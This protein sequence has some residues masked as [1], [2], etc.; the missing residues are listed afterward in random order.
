MKCPNCS[1]ENPPTNQFCI[2]CGARL[3]IAQA[4][5]SPPQSLTEEI[6]QLRRLFQ[7]MNDRLSALEQRQGAAPS[8]AGVE[9]V[10]ARPAE[11]AP[12]APA[13]RVE[14]WEPQPV[15]QVMQ[16]GPVTPPVTP[17]PPAAPSVSK[18][19]RAPR[20]WEQILG[21]NW[22]ARI[23]AL[24]LL[25]GVGFFLKFAFDRNWIVPVLRI[26]IGVVAGLS[27]LGG[28]YL[29]R[30]RYPV[31][32]QVLTGGGIGV[33]YLSIFAA[34]ATYDILP[35]IA[36]VVL[37]VFTCAV[38][39]FFALRYNSMALAILG[40][41]GAFIAPFMLAGLATGR[42]AAGVSTSGY[43]IL[44]YILII[45]IGVLVTATFRNW[46]WFTLLAL[47]F[48]LVIFGT[49][50]DLFGRSAG[51]AGAEILL[52]LMFLLF[53]GATM[54]FHA[55]WKQLPK[56]FDYTLMVFNALS[57]V[58]I[59]LALLNRD[60]QAWLGGFTFILALFYGG[61]AYLIYRRGAENRRLS[62]F[63]TGIALVLLTLAIPIQ[64]GDRAATTI[65]WAAEATVLVWLSL[66]QN[67]TYFRYTGYAG[68]VLVAVR[69]I[70]FDT[71][72][73]RGAYIP[74]F[75]ERMLAFIISVAA[76]YLSSWLIW[77][78]QTGEGQS[79]HPVFLVAGNILSL[80]VIGFEVGDYAAIRFPTL[81]DDNS[82]LLL[83]ALAV[84]ITLYHLIWRRNP[85][86]YDIVLL[87]GN[88]IVFV[89]LSIVI[90]ND[91]RTW[92]GPLYFALAA[93]HAILAAV[94]LRRGAENTLF[95]FFAAGVAI[96]FL[97][98]GF[99]IQFG[100][101]AW[102]TIAWSSEAVLLVW[103][104]LRFKMPMLR[105]ASLSVFG[106]TAIRLLF[107]DATVDISR[108]TPL[109]NER[110]LAFV[111]AVAAMCLS[112]YLM[113]KNR[114]R[115][116]AG[117]QTTTLPGLFIA[118]NFFTLWVLTAEVWN[119]FDRQLLSVARTSETGRALR[120]LQS[121]SITG[122][123]AFYAV[124]ALVFG[125]FRR[126]R[127][128]RLGALSLLLIAILKVFVF[129]VLTLAMVYRIIAFIG[130]GLLLLT[131]A[132]LYQRFRKNI[133]EFLSKE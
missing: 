103:L 14:F 94:M 15:A 92:I 22:L 113:A 69:L 127:F 75:N 96:F 93:F 3:P 38:S 95:G 59:S 78:K 46:R 123:W 98:A 111:C 122:L 105:W 82:L 8:P 86:V 112:G 61:L 25:I 12:V 116:S 58:S 83:M 110:F 26:L 76:M 131:S 87:V 106:I 47:L 104:S 88:T 77:R 81:S 55:V 13:P 91:L 129:D 18:P 85:R 60:Y 29:W 66:K 64:L 32:T 99:P 19:P 41:V 130:L 63:A 17:P 27:M 133:V 52:T 6:A 21:G 23:G 7:Q 97:T 119:V 44:G 108:Y 121:L 57:Y 35:F 117:E 89:I 79:A 65:A 36:A 10:E 71:W 80:W 101:K 70:F 125:I 118:A 33:V 31:L 43:E 54:L 28:G 39:V 9:P 114:N 68:F 34:F 74:V 84:A 40:I 120:S 115:L 42:P 62:L 11:Q 107:F 100:D 126:V 109:V 45:D 102:T 5:S 56:P 16:A 4:Q 48:S 124:I 51:V 1:K 132:Y 53:V 2:F 67:I 24:A 30:K 49:W 50:Y 73:P 37:L 72:L 128:L 20:E 90:W